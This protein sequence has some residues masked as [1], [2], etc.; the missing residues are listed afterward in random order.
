[1]SISN[2]LSNVGHAI[3]EGCKV[4]YKKTVHPLVQLAC[5]VLFLDIPHYT[6]TIARKV[7]HLFTRTQ[8][9]IVRIEEAVSTVLPIKRERV[10]LSSFEPTLFQPELREEGEES[11]NDETEERREKSPRNP[12]QPIVIEPREEIEEPVSHQVV[13]GREE[14]PRNPLQ[15][16]VI[17]PREEMEEPVSHQVV[18]GREES[19]RNPLQPI[20]IEPREEIEELVNDQIEDRI[21]S[22]AGEALQ[23][24]IQIVQ[25]ELEPL[26]VLV[27]STKRYVA[28][29]NIPFYAAR[30]G[31]PNP[32]FRNC[33]FNSLSVVCAHAGYK[34]PVIHP[35][36]EKLYAELAVANAEEFKQVLYQK[37]AEC[38]EKI[39][40]GEIKLRGMSE[41]EKTELAEIECRIEPT[42]KELD[43]VAS[44]LKHFNPS[45][46]EIKEDERLP[47][48]RKQLSLLKQELV[49]DE[50]E[51]LK[52][53]IYKLQIAI[54]KR[55]MEQMVLRNTIAKTEEKIKAAV[56]VKKNELERREKELKDKKGQWGR[57][58]GEV[59][60]E[61][62]S[63]KREMTEFETALEN[64]EKLKRGSAVIAILRGEIEGP[65]TMEDAQILSAILTHEVKSRTIYNGT[66]DARSDLGHMI[67]KQALYDSDWRALRVG[68]YGHW[69]VYVRNPDGLTIDEIN[70]ATIYR[71]RMTVD[72]LFA[73]YSNPDEWR[74]TQITFYDGIN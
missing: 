43:E 68:G 8:P 53:D 45:E 16:I 64:Q 67:L 50:S 62:I 47:P 48:L 36:N 20:A 57:E 37:I 58:M 42:K 19:P 12:L 51:T 18:E 4:V 70:D 49:T 54:N 21:E 41:Q 27:K 31:F 30:V 24:S 44:Q 11:V 33:S 56:E 14:S 13:E 29:S 5:K 9:T 40:L 46:W 72:Q 63:M 17:E 22:E 59:S 73:K 25:K 66:E 52:Q 28:N 71:K 74:N 10:D 3:Y 69:W 23:Q 26:P 55:E 35:D 2:S 1:M 6:G 15:P 65:L 7:I 34:I 32:S 38:Q 61:I 39:A 60:R